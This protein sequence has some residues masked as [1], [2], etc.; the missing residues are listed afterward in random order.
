MITAEFFLTSLV[1]VFIP[2]TGVIYTVSTGLFM[3]WRASI[4]AA[5]GCTIGILPHL[6]GCVLGLSA[7][8]HLSSVAF[9]L[10]KFAG[11]AYLLYLAWSMWRDKGAI[12]FE[13]SGQKRRFMQIVSK[14]FL[15][16]ILNPKLSIFFLA[17]LPQFISS[18][19]SAPSI[20]MAILSA[21]FM[22]LT[23]IVF[24]AYGCL[25]HRVSACLT[26]SP[27]AI[28]KVQQSF[29]VAFAGLGIKLALTEQ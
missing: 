16:N 8:L 18:K 14:G 12:N 24:V 15:I 7:I 29:A 25:A 23:F 26:N 17:F 20:Q 3:G 9:Q 5:S 21:V 6:L 1:V 4:A 2:G 10:L 11:A 22:L 28:R 19:G 27:R 13:T